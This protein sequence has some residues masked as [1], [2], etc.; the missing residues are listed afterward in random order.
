MRPRLGP[1]SSLISLCE[2]WVEGGI[3]LSYFIARLIS[4]F[5]DDG[6][7][8]P[9]GKDRCSRNAEARRHTSLSGRRFLRG[10]AVDVHHSARP[11][12]HTH[13]LLLRRRTPFQRLASC[14]LFP[15]FTFLSLARCLSE[16]V[17]V[18]ACWIRASCSKDS[19]RTSRKTLSR[20]FG[21][22]SR[23][24]SVASFTPTSV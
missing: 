4:A 5:I 24:S 9:A 18:D 15:M 21:E 7:C 1:I 3:L 20:L 13:T 14:A 19:L 12:T 16:L 10:R 22:L 6:R 8:R 2:E 17:D 11:C 23:L